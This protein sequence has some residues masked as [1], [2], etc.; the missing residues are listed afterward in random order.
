MRRSGQRHSK[1]FLIQDFFKLRAILF[2]LSEQKS[3]A[4]AV[5]SWK[6]RS[7]NL[8]RNAALYLSSSVL[9]STD[10]AS[11]DIRGVVKHL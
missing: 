7:V 2:L 5:A 1:R 6:E 9:A 8:G 10:P 4:R 3:T 11:A